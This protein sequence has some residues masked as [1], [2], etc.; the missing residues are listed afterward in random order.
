M[1]TIQCK[2]CFAT[3]NPEQ[4]HFSGGNTLK[5]E[6]CGTVHIFDTNKA[7]RDYSAA[8]K[9]RQFL[10]FLKNQMSNNFSDADV[11]Q[12]CFDMIG[13][14]GNRAY[15]YE[16]IPG[17]IRVLKCQ[18]LIE[19]ATRHNGVNELIQICAEANRSFALA[20]EGYVF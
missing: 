9:N 14:T 13:L 10:L 18:N 8:S 17:S 4:K 12:L 11:Q 19:A 5:C 16:D 3:L 2:N 20:V 15:N 1:K 7:N 6:Y